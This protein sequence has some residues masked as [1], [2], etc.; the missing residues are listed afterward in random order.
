MDQAS[1]FENFDDWQINWNERLKKWCQE[2][3]RTFLRQRVEIRLATLLWRK[4]LKFN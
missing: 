3:E 1:R 4:V 2:K